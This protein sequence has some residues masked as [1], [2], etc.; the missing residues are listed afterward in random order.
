MS[1]KTSAAKLAVV[2]VPVVQDSGA[3]PLSEIG[4]SDD[5]GRFEQMQREDNQA[6][7]AEIAA[8]VT[9]IVQGD[10][11]SDCVYMTRGDQRTHVNHNSVETMSG[12]GWELEKPA[13][14]AKKG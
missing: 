6:R 13:A 7:A 5:V 2:R 8:A 10:V 11:H 1:K 3:I 14:K 9:S 4:D 12:L